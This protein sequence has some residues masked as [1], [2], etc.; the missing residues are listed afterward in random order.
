MNQFD[1]YFVQV[2]SKRVTDLTKAGVPRARI[3]RRPNGW[4]VYGRRS[5]RRWIYVATLAS[6]DL[7]NVAAAEALAAEWS[8]KGITASVRYHAS[9]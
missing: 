7:A 1:F 6:F 8:A 5:F 2:I 4:A 9:D 3:E